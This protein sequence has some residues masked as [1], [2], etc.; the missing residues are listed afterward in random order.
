MEQDN[1]KERGGET[2]Q[3]Q[4]HLTLNNQLVGPMSHEEEKAPTS[5]KEDNSMVKEVKTKTKKKRGRT[6]RTSRERGEDV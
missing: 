2:G 1:G 5:L 6:D 3:G 4:K